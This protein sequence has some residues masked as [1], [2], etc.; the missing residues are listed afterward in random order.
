MTTA[1]R[2]TLTDGRVEA[3]ISMNGYGGTDWLVI[4]TRAGRCLHGIPARH[5]TTMARAETGAKKMMK[6]A[7]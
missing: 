1:T 5:Y 6:K 7:A 2:K 4:V 3:N